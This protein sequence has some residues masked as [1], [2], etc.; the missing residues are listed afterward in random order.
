MDSDTALAGGYD[1]RPEGSGAWPELMDAD[2]ED[3]GLEENPWAWAD[4]PEADQT[5]RIDVASAHVTAVLV[6]FDAVRWLPATLTAL[7]KVDPRPA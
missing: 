4:F 6:T 7:A 5:Q 1:D 3:F 2:V